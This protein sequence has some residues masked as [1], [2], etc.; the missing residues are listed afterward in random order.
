M[1]VYTL[2]RVGKDFFDSFYTVYTS[3]VVVI[4]VMCVIIR[5]LLVPY[6]RKQVQL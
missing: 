1:V 3:F 4:I 2:E 5:K 6:G